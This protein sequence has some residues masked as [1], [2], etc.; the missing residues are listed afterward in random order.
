[1]LF[2]V[3]LAGDRV[4][5]AERLDLSTR[6]RDIAE[7]QDGPMLIWNDNGEIASPLAR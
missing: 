2:R 1:M 4:I 7:G 3:H 5:Y 6:V